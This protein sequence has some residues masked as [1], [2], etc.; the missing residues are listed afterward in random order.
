MSSDLTVT[1]FSRTSFSRSLS[2]MMA[3]RS[4]LSVMSAD[5]RS[6]R[7]CCSSCAVMGSPSTVAMMRSTTSARPD[8]TARTATTASALPQPRLMAAH[9][10]SRRSEA[11]QERSQLGDHAVVVRRGR[12]ERERRAARQPQ[13]ALGTSHLLQQRLHAHWCGVV[14][15]DHD[16][17]PAAA[18]RDHA[19]VLQPAAE[20][21]HAEQRGDQRRARAGAVLQL[22]GDR[23]EGGDPPD[24]G[25][26]LVD[27]QSL[28]D[29]RD[30]ALRD[31][32]RDAELD[33]RLEVGLRMLTAQ[34]AH[35]LLEQMGVELE[36]DGRDVPRLLLSQ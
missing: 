16:R 22:G 34:L 10:V 27:D 7:N 18:G 5:A 25:Q 19:E 13:R 8:P 21:H 36:P 32:G 15:L 28:A 12:T 23:L 9:R 1:P 4:S 24:A 17:V 14:E 2:V 11:L 20:L 30:I 6:W 26:T 29:V 31:V 33:L 35:R 3:S